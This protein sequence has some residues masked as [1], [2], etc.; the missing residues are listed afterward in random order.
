MMVLVQEQERVQVLLEMPMM[1]QELER[2]QAE[3]L[4]VQAPAVV[5]QELVL[6]P[7]KESNELVRVVVLLELVLKLPLPVV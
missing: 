1:E 7:K 2:A 4:L 5:R 3:A 6:Q